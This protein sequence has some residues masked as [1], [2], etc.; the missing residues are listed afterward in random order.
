MKNVVS[1][2]GPDMA[3]PLVRSRSRFLLRARV[4]GRTG[5]YR[6]MRPDSWPVPSWLLLAAAIATEVV[7]TLLLRFSEGFTRPLASVGVLAGYAVSIVLFSRVLDRGV[8]LG[9]AYGTLTGC[10]LAAAALLSAVVL[11]DPLTP[12]QIVGLVLLA[13]GVLTL[14]SARKPAAS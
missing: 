8:A 5:R 7:G 4:L 12:A 1:T 9:I 13:G 2:R 3:A 11:G 10:G 6:D 14:Q